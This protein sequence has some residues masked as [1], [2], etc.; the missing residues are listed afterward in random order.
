MIAEFFQG[1]HLNSPNDV[2]AHPDGSY[3]FT[4]PIA[5][6]SLYEG[7]PDAPGG[8]RNPTGLLNGKVGQPVGSGTLKGELTSNIYRADPSG[9]VDMLIS[10]EAFG[11]GAS[12]CVLYVQ[13]GLHR[14][15]TASVGLRHRC[16]QQDQQPEAVLRS[17]GRWCQVR[18][19]RH[20]VRYLRQP[21]VRQQ[22]WRQP[23]GA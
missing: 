16:R 22:C 2:A 10:E 8:L 9:R 12:A 6:A 1:K 5:G 14:Q 19:R 11:G 21:V 18:N 13:E 3:W 20:P 7:M 23:V 4:D 15:S 17:D